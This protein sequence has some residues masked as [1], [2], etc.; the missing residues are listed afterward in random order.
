MTAAHPPGDPWSQAPL[1][2]EI[3]R[4]LSASSGPVNWEFARQ[5]GI[6]TASFGATEPATGESDRRSLA[7]AVRPAELAVAAFTGLPAS[8][9]IAEVRSLGRGQTVQAS[10]AELRELIDPIAAR[11]GAELA[12]GPGA[13]GLPGFAPPMEGLPEAATGP[14]VAVPGA[15]PEEMRQALAGVGSLLMGAQVGTALGTLAQRVFGQFDLA[16]PRPPRTAMYFVAPNIVRFE[17]DWS[18]PREDLRGWIALHEVAHR[19]GLSRPWARPHFA[20]LIRDLAEHA[21]LDLPGLASRLEGMD[22]SD[23]GAMAQA[24]QGIGNI[25][26]AASTPDQ[27]LRVARVQAF[28]VV[29][30]A[31]ADH[32]MDAVGPHLVGSYSQVAEAIRRQHE[33]RPADRALEQLLGLEMSVD[34]YRL[35]QTFCRTVAE[36]SS[37]EILARMWDSAEALPSMPELEEPTLWLS[38]TA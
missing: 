17:S 22:L 12:K 1:F 28:L 3:Q 38:R 16:V 24:F 4:V 7:E 18:L 10:I 27:R 23:P 20:G 13:L 26:G 6:A 5:I 35:G 21:E 36:R 30:E 31:W 37:Q 11:L 29:A 8:D 2:R 9:E 25:F 14:G 33:G 34:L 32:V 19:F 15:S